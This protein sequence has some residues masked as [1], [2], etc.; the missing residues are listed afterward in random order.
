MFRFKQFSIDQTNA[1]FKVGTDGILLGAWCNTTEAK[2]SIDIGTGTG[3]I[4]IMLAQRTN[5]PVTAVEINE[6]AYK[7]AVANVDMSP[8]KE[9]I[10]LTNK[11]LQQYCNQFSLEQ[12][13]DLIVS[14]PPYFVNSLK[15]QD[16]DKSNARH[17]DTLSQKDIIIRSKQIITNKGK[18]CV[19]LPKDEG[20]QFI[21]TAIENGWFLTKL[22]NVYP[23]PKKP[24]KRLLIE[25]S[26]A[27]KPTI[28]D[29]II[30][31]SGNA[32]HD[33][34]EEYK[35]LTKEFYIIF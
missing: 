15:S 28:E 16:I 27:F 24:I 21:K 9:N 25:L 14:N 3:I 23:N 29:S 26:L 1:P 6:T 4:A 32:R 2:N 30:I 34:T 33:Y 10:Q 35:A 11:S 12:K 8:W 13:F 17:T 22:T 20:T 7:Q 18:L 31:E 19:V 5:N